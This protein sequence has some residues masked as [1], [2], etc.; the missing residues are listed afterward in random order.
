[1]KVLKKASQILDGVDVEAEVVVDV[2]PEEPKA[3]EDMRAGVNILMYHHLRTFTQEALH[4]MD[5]YACLVLSCLVI[6]F[7]ELWSL[8]SACKDGTQ[9]YKNSL[10]MPTWS[11]L[12]CVKTTPPH[13]T[14]LL[15]P[16]AG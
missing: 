5:R 2:V 10:S 14:E 15:T 1:M 13:P 6:C 7:D 8:K 11:R 4:S 16:F 3:G 12:L 9:V